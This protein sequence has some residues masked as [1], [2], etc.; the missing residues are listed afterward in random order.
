LATYICFYKW[1]VAITA[2]IVN[3]ASK[4]VCTSFL[5]KAAHAIVINEGDDTLY[6]SML[7]S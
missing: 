1:I 2:A 4:V 3:A 5:S 7:S 6:I